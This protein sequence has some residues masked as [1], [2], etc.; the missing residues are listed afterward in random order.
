MQPGLLH[1]R[2]LTALVV[3]ALRELLF[4][5]FDGGRRETDAQHAARF[6]D[7]DLEDQQDDNF[8][9]ASHAQHLRPGLTV[10]HAEVHVGDRLPRLGEMLEEQLDHRVE[11]VLLDEGYEVDSSDRF[12]EGSG[13]LETRDFDLVVADA[14]LNDGNGIQL[15]DIARERG[16][17]AVIMTGYAFVVPG[18]GEAAR[19][20]EVLL[21]PI[22]PE[23]LLG[24]IAKALR[25]PD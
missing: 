14:R 24:A 13:L 15:A 4:H 10:L 19:R 3:P 2:R 22:S 25:E 18:L 20:Y 23:E 17:A 8:V 6:G 21:K 1:R 16:I 12:E 5:R 7:A 11:H 9:G